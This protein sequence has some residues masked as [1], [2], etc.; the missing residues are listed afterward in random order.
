MKR[1]V[2]GGL[3]VCG[4]FL[5]GCASGTKSEASMGAVSAESK[6]ECSAKSSCCKATCTKEGEAAKAPAAS[7]N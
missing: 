7:S 2:A 3:L 1:L 4:L 6:S 5:V